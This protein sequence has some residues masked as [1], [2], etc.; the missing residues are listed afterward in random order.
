MKWMRKK[1]LLNFKKT[2]KIHV[3][4]LSKIL[5]AY[6]CFL[7]NY[8][9]KLFMFSFFFSSSLARFDF[10]VIVYNRTVHACHIIAIWIRPIPFFPNVIWHIYEENVSIAGC[11]TCM[12]SSLVFTTYFNIAS[13]NYK[14]EMLIQLIGARH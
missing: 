11:V 5:R 8:T 3:C 13:I 2:G 14:I 9:P 6:K 4:T 7:I 12:I 1:K 10:I